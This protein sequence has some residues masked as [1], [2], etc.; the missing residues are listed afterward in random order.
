MPAR[1]PF[2]SFWSIEEGSSEASSYP[3]YTASMGLIRYENSPAPA[4]WVYRWP[5][6]CIC[7]LLFGDTLFE[8]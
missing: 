3:E 6:L 7:I 2:V 8:G 1:A 4:L 5:S